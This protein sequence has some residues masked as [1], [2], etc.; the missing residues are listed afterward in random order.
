MEHRMQ[1]R[2]VLT[3]NFGLVRV[4]IEASAGVTPHDVIEHARKAALEASQGPV[5]FLYAV[6]EHDLLFAG[7]RPEATA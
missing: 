6:G 3:N 2:E 4:R 5:E 1:V 7:P